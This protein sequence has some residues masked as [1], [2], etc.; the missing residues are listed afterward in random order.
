MGTCDLL[1]AVLRCCKVLQEEDLRSFGEM[2]CVLLMSGEGW[3]LEDLCNVSLDLPM[4]HLLLKRRSGTVFCDLHV[5]GEGLVS[6][7]LCDVGRSLLPNC[8]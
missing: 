6:E 5:D 1:M 3:V 7:D 8:A 2:F 4:E